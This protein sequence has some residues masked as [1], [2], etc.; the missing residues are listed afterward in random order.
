MR[1]LTSSRVLAALVL[2]S[3]VGTAR[4][5]FPIPPPPSTLLDTSIRSAAMG[6]A[7][8]AVM[9]GEPDVWANPSTLAGVHGIGWV[10]GHTKLAPE[11]SDD[12]AFGSQRLL[13]GGGGIGISI[14][15]QPISGLGKA[16]LDLPAEIF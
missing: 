4:A 14:M 3:L 16:H 5:Q 10:A 2:C 13:F 11:L 1:N 15:G 7:G 9:W 12:W 6:G 8:A